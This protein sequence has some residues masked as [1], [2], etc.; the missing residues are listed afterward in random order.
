[1]L[2]NLQGQSDHEAC[3]PHVQECH[4]MSLFMI[5]IRIE[6]RFGD[7]NSEDGPRNKGA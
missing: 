5:R 2:G 4:R 3:K 7:S 1:M 6:K